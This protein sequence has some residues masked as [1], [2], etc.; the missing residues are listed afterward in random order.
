MS[1]DGSLPNYQKL[2]AYLADLL[3][4][5]GNADTDG[6]GD[7]DAGDTHVLLGRRPDIAAVPLDAEHT[8]TELPYLDI[9]NEVLEREV[10]TGEKGAYEELAGMEHPATLPFSLAH[11][12]VRR[13]LRHLG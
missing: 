11:E 12:R 2:F 8:A 6:D 7:V 9:V 3:R 1:M 5:I 13:A 4:L 10:A